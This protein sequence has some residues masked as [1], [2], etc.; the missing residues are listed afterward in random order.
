[1]DYRKVYGGTP[2]GNESCCDTCINARIVKGYAESE[3]ITIC[4]L[5]YRSL[6]IPFKVRECSDYVDRRLPEFDQMEK[7]AL[8]L[9]WVKSS[10]P[11]GF[12]NSAECE[13]GS[14]E[15]TTENEK[16]KEAA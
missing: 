4:D 8:D 3:R 2:V 1:M 7:I 15:E 14:P 6:V 9:S 5:A 12:R 11:A 10:R 16:N 13:N